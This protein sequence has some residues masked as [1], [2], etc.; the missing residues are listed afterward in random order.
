MQ[1]YRPNQVT[2]DRRA[3]AE[4][5]SLLRAILPIGTEIWQVCK[6]AGY[7][8]G[9][10]VAAGLG[11]DAGLRRFCVG[12][13][14][15]ALELKA[16][17]PEAEV[18]LFPSAAAEDLPALATAGVIVTVHNA[19]SLSAMLERGRGSPF[20]IKVNTGLNRF[21]F[22]A[23]E[24]RSALAQVKATDADALRGIYTHFSQSTDVERLSKGRAL[25]EAMLAEAREILGRSVKSMAAASPTALVH[26]GL[27]YDAV[28]P[29][30]A[31]YGMLTGAEA[32][33]RHLQPVVTSITSRLLDSRT[34]AEGMVAG[35]GYGAALDGKVTRIGTM[36]I[37]HFHGLAGCGLGT[38]IIRGRE[39]P[40]LA[41]TLLA[42]MIDLSDVLE[43]EDGDLITL[44]GED[45]AIKRDLFGLAENLGTSAT[46]LHFGLIR[47]LNEA[48]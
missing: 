12:T 16:A 15:E 34:F 24:L 3:F 30:R 45:G 8:L 7:G 2:L 36:P 35:A 11:Y 29:G 43:A 48:G 26:P 18:L 19:A 14:G 13:P 47:A 44:V 9:T 6:G 21:G 10:V 5:L 31:L 4:N 42:S 41:R 27:P 25:Y 28:D 46:M 17:L 20:F 39:T 23:A 37:G 22:D 1:K 40:V 38:V 33:G 32:G